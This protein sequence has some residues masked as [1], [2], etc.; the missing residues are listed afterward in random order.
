MIKGPEH[1]KTDNTDCP[2]GIKTNRKVRPSQQTERKRQEG[3][4]ENRVIV[5]G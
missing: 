1:K 2:V 5:L 3:K 4:W